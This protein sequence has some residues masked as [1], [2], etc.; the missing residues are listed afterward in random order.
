MKSA[1]RCTS[2]RFANAVECLLWVIV[3]A[4]ASFPQTAPGNETATAARATKIN[5]STAA[6]IKAEFDNVPCK[7][8]A[9]LSAVKAL[10]EKLGAPAEELQIVKLKNV[11]NL[12]VRKPGQSEEKIV[13]GAHYDKV[14]HGCGALDNW[15]GI[16]ALAHL[17][18]TLKEAQT[19]KT[20]LFVAFGREEEGLIGSAAMVKEIAKEQLPQYCTMVNLDSFGLAAPQVM[21]NTSSP[22]LEVLAEEVAKQMQMPFAKAAIQGADADSSS[23]LSK[24]IPAVTLH[25]LNNDWRTMLHSGNDQAS[26]VNAE[27]VYYG[28]RLALSMLVRLDQADCQA[29]R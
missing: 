26:K 9:R 7:N 10:F 20:L 29:F 12:V 2:M 14:S 6:E 3:L 25:G 19:N 15:T 18:R 28:Y 5:I 8:D 24:K 27:S 1:T 16:V 21:R 22:K 11:E 13:I 23:F 4:D 17:Y